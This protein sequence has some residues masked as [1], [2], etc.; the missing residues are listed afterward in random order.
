MQELDEIRDL[1]G[2]QVE[3]SN[4]KEYDLKQMLKNFRR[5]EGSI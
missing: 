1:L 5:Y 4:T 2:L 3:L